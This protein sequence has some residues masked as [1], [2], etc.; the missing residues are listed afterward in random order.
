[1]HNKIFD[2]FTSNQ[3]ERIIH[4]VNVHD[5]LEI[6]KDNDE[7]LLMEADTLGGLDVSRTKGTFDKAS[8][9]R[10]MKIVRNKRLPHFITD[11]AKQKFEELYNLRLKFYQS[12]SS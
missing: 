3:K 4:L 8:N 7:L 10:Y 2:N 11:Y 1:L 12:T 9:D 5:T 6:L